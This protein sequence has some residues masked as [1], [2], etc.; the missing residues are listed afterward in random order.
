MQGFMEVQGAVRAAEA[1]IPAWGVVE[2][3]LEGVR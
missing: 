3:F 2:G 1:P